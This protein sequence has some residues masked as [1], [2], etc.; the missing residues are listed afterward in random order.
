M[1][2]YDDDGKRLLDVTPRWTPLQNIKGKGQGREWGVKRNFHIFNK[3][4]KTLNTQ[5][6]ACLVFKIQ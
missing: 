3:S 4:V 6:F 2:D 5:Y 1:S